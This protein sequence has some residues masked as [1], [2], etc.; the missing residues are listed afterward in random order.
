MRVV[1]VG[2]VLLDRDLDG[3]STRLCPDAPVPVVD[4]ERTAV[5]AG[6][7]GLVARLLAADGH[8]PALVPLSARMPRHA[9]FA[10]ASSTSKWWP[11]PRTVPRR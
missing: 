1:V 3:P 4:V 10:A 11:D 2:D 7:A 9:S 8:T 6:G 5:R